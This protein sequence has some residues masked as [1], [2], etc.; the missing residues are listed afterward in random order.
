[1]N[2]ETASFC[3]DNQSQ[4]RIIAGVGSDD[5]TS[6][7]A[8]RVLLVTSVLSTFLALGNLAAAFTPLEA[9]SRSTR[10]SASSSDASETY[11]NRD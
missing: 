10:S 4:R 5:Q 11:A 2:D 8:V 7:F 3:T 1:M 6:L 9:D